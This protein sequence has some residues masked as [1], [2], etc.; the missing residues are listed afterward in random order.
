M[1]PTI[2]IDYRDGRYVISI[3]TDSVIEESVYTEGADIQIPE[4]L[5]SYLEYRCSSDSDSRGCASTRATPSLDYNEDMP[6]TQRFH[7]W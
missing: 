5:E 4:I 1:K 6:G 2:H 3:G 7:Q